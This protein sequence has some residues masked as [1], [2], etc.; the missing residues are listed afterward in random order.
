M[1]Q[2]GLIFKTQF[3]FSF[4]FYEKD[5]EMSDSLMYSS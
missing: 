1:D 4:G 3:D 2:K 5:I